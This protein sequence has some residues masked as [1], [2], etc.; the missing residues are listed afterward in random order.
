H[1]LELPPD[2]PLIDAAEAARRALGRRGPTPVIGAAGTGPALL[3]RALA[4]EGNVPV[5]YVCADADGARRA[6]ADL[7]YLSRRLPAVAPKVQALP[8]AAATLLLLPA[9]TQPYADVHPDRRA[10]MLRAGTLAHLAA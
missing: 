8:E 2:R 4:A 7:K 10:A 6:A 3:A 5:L 1:A 9:E